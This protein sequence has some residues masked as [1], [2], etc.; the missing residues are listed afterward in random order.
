WRAMLDV[1]AGPLL[2]VVLL[3]AN[4]TLAA[5]RS[6]MVGASR[7]KLRHMAE[8]GTAGPALA[9]RVAEDATPLIATIR[10]AQSVCR[11]LAAGLIAVL[12]EP[13]L[14]AL[15]SQAPALADFAD[16]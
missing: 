7:A 6:A 9:A 12:F 4:S 10:L 2:L 8:P 1:P 13:W 15:V 3:L 16:P 5:A 14:A 11:F